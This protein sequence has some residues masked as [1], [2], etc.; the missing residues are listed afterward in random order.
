MVRYEISLQMQMME[1]CIFSHRD[2]TV[3]IFMY[4]KDLFEKAGIK[5]TPTTWKEFEEDCQKLADIGE[6]P[7][8]IGGS[9]AWQI[10]RYLSFSPWR[11]TGPEFIH[12]ISGW[13]RLFC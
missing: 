6:I 13:N 5:D 12:G 3:N 7:V 9:D 4:R 11:V 10:M 2:C 8:I 1:I